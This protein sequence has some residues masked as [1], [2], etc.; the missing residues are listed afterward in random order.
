M[1]VTL[2]TPDV[3][4]A[5]SR[6]EYNRYEWHRIVDRYSNYGNPKFYK[7]VEKEDFYCV[8]QTPEGIIFFKEISYMSCLSSASLFSLPVME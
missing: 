1:K 4:K 2:V 5:S 8:Y 3:V 7:N 6:S